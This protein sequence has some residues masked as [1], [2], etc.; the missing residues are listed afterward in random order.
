MK[1]IHIRQ[2]FFLI[3]ALLL[4]LPI[5]ACTNN[6]Q[7]PGDIVREPP[8]QSMPANQDKEAPQGS[9]PD[10]LFIMK[11]VDI[12]IPPQD[13]HKMKEAGINILTTE[14]GM[15]EKPEKAKAF[16]DKA[17]NAG[18][19]VVMDA[20]F[21]YPAWGFT[22]DDFDK[23]PPDKRPVW[24][25]SRVQEWVKEF[26]DHPAVF[27]WDMCNEYGENL[28]SGAFSKD[29]EWPDTAITLEQLRQ[30]RQDILQ[31]NPDKPVM[32]RMNQQS[33][34]E[35]FGG[36]E[37]NFSPNIAEVVMLN[38]YS[39]YLRNGSLLWPTIIEDIAQYDVDV[40]TGID[41][42]V[43]IWISLAAFEDIGLF[44]KPTPEMLLNDFEDTLQVSGINGVGFF[45]WGPAIDYST[46]RIW[47]LPESGDDLWK[48]IRFVIDEYKQGN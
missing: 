17:H 28:P 32:I 1:D 35:P 41:P 21:S 16:L 8:E 31:I 23:L 14:W 12:N 34:E 10:I 37:G 30:A 42:D 48:L 15:E 38:L 19:K 44:Q 18:L 3:L 2:I 46:G 4:M 26:K 6:Q 29:T 36:I 11:G 39:N 40:L 7:Q 47:Y 33:F 25:K 9:E 20:G 22:V 13:F 43:N 24:Q 27:G 5:M 45:S